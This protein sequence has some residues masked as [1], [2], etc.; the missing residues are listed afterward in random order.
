[1]VTVPLLIARSCTAAITFATAIAS[2]LAKPSAQNSFTAVGINPGLRSATTQR[3]TFH[4]APSSFALVVITASA[5]LWR[6]SLRVIS[7][8]RVK[9][10][11]SALSAGTGEATGPDRGGVTL[12]T[13]LVMC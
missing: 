5:L 13:E 9:L 4:C 8:T 1:M 7:D 11:T 6:Y 2:P 12:V 3:V 10:F